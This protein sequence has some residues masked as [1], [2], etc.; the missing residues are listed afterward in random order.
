MQHV[1]TTI[2]LLMA[3]TCT[4][5]GMAIAATFPEYFLARG[6]GSSVTC[7]DPGPTAAFQAVMASHGIDC[8]AEAWA[9]A[10]AAA[11]D[12]LTAQ[13]KMA[14][15]ARSC[16]L[17]ARVETGL[18]LAD[19]G[20]VVSENGPV[21]VVLDGGGYAVITGVGGGNVSLASGATLSA[22]AFEV[23]WAGGECLVIGGP[24]TS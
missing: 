5:T 10:L 22:A 11:P 9:G 13:E 1:L 18:S 15:A 21:V 4:V 16:G 6:D 17:S 3:V 20:E 12:N 24:A 14:L 23:R 19:L 8:G 2:I 7:P